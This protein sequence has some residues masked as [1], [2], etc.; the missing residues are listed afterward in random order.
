MLELYKNYTA[1]APTKPSGVP[2][3]L[4][5]GVVATVIVAA[6]VAIVLRKRK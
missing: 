2:A 6:V 1:S 3:G 4:I 5:I